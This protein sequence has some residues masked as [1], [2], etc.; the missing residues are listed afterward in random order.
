[1]TGKNRWVLK[2]YLKQMPSKSSRVRRSTQFRCCFCGKPLKGEASVKTLRCSGCGAKF[3]ITRNARRCLVQIAVED[4]GAGP[5]CCQQ[6]S[7]AI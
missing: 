4:C 7:E 1:M 2:E 6:R 5:S 3:T